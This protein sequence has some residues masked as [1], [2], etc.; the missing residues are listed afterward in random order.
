MNESARNI[1]FII[2]G[3]CL[4]VALVYFLSNRKP[5]SYYDYTFRVADNVW[6]GSVAYKQY[7]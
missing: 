1:K 6:R 3:L 4:A 5:Q 2:F 7:A